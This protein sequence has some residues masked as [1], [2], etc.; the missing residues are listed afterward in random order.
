MDRF[1]TRFGI[2][3]DAAIAV[4]TFSLISGWWTCNHV[5]RDCFYRGR[6][7]RQ[8]F[9]ECTELCLHH[10]DLSEALQLVEIAVRALHD[11]EKV[12]LNLFR[13]FKE[14][15]DSISDTSFNRVMARAEE[16]Y[17][18]SG[19]MDDVKQLR[20][21]KAED[22]VNLD[23]SMSFIH[24]TFLPIH[25]G[26]I[27]TPMSTMRYGQMGIIF[28][29]ITRVDSIVPH[30]SEEFFQEKINMQ[31]R[32]RRM[33][34]VC[35]YTGSRSRIYNLAFAPIEMVGYMYNQDFRQEVCKRLEMDFKFLHSLTTRS[36]PRMILQR[37]ALEA[38]GDDSGLIPYMV[39]TER[40]DNDDSLAKTCLKRIGNEKWESW[41]FPELLCRMHNL[42]MISCQE[43]LDFMESE[44]HCQICFLAGRGLDQEIPVV[45]TRLSELTGV[46]PLRTVSNRAHADGNVKLAEHVLHRTQIL[47]KVSNHWVV[48]NAS[49]AMEA[50]IL[51]ASCIHRNVRGRG[52]WV[53]QCWQDA[54]YQLGRVLFR[55]DFDAKGR[56]NLMRLFFFISFGFLPLDNGRIPVW[57]DLGDFLKIITGGE[58]NGMDSDVEIY[59]LML[60][61]VH[62]VI[63]LA[64]QNGVVAV[65]ADDQPVE[66]E[67]QEHGYEIE[68]HMHNE[69]VR[70]TRQ[71]NYQ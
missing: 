8:F 14:E 32:V 13:H 17:K 53:D 29:D 19:M 50:F 44:V 46:N 27:C 54:M 23:D 63:Y 26:H 3:G 40:E 52:L 34:P 62:N 60:N 51:T 5:R 69:F 4:K 70:R 12:W 25:D 71:R 22:R 1:I 55:F 21:V 66:L 41:V 33:L 56:T 15:D 64:N 39:K 18:H 11:R 42:R 43:I 68:A 6:C 38:R 2:C 65:N 67:R 48:T 10:D 58:I 7:A 45:D 35:P 30:D 20:L 24:F 31:S 37:T 61:A 36:G 9:N 59:T 16:L 47:T 57:R 49:S 28:I